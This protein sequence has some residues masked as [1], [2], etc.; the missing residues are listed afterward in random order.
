[1]AAPGKALT[2]G[3]QIQQL[4]NARKMVLE[5]PAYYD[6]IVKG[7]LPIIG[8]SSPI[9]LRRW[10]AEFLAESLATPVL[11]SR[12]KENLT[13]AILDTL[14]L[15][16]EGPNDDVLVF[17]SSVMAAASA[18]PI[19][20]RWIIHN[21]Y[22][23]ESW[24]AMTAIK[25]KILQIWD[26]AP[27]PV[28]IC[29]IKFVQRV[30]LAQTASN[31][32]EQK[33]NGLDV[34][35]AMIP[36]NHPLLDPRLLEAEAAGL[37]DR[38]LA[39]L[40]DN[41]SDAL[42]VDATLNTLAILIRTRPS[43]SNRILN[44]VL[45]F[46]PL[47]LANSPLTP[48]TKV[49]IKSMEK[50]TRILLLHLHKRDPNNPMAGRIQQHIERLSRSR[51]EIFDDA[52]RKRALVQPPGADYGEAKR[53]R[54]DNSAPQ[55]HARPWV[56][57][58]QSLAAVF[59]LTNTPGLDGF[60]AT[61]VPNE[62]AAKI[63]VKA[64]ATTSPQ[65][66][67]QAVDAV[68]FRLRTLYAAAPPVQPPALN[69][70]TQPLGVDEDDDDG[71]EPDYYVA[72]DTEQILNKLD[73]APPEEPVGQAADASSALAP[74]GPFKLPPPPLVDPTVAIKV[75]Q[76]ASSR[77]FGP[78][79]SLEEA[80]VRKHKAGINRLAASSYDRDSWL[81]LI[82]RMATRSVAGLEDVSS[83]IKAEDA[84]SA[85]DRPQMSLSNMIRELL[86]NYVLEDWRRR[87]EVAV[88]WLCEEWY[89]DQVTKRGQLDAP[90]H[91]EKWA[92]RL[93]DGFLNYITAQDKVLTRFLAEIPELSRAL[94]GRLKSVCGDPT[95]I[96]LVLTTLLY[97]VMMRPP[98]REIALDTVAAIWLEYEE[99]RPLASKYLIK[100]RPG[101][102]ES[103]QTGDAASSV[104]PVAT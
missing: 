28:R 93:V 2:V 99:A 86:Y 56:P 98:V 88:A 34:S 48:K 14:Q 77:V 95:K 16:V 6:K 74:L 58:P 104:M 23:K 96:Q 30:I 87:I 50:T 36:P 29:C 47:K 18:Y 44:T 3:E 39:V 80:A 102:I 82:T 4:N 21:S 38:M 24:E 61:Q 94:L 7:I 85:L 22:H 9:E 43:T 100:W 62:L 65:L 90:L 32:M 25:A 91:Y 84:R 92:L 8:P 52:N 66:L 17:K 78:L 53:Q 70:D 33:I 49:L 54:T 67:S 68:R 10:G 89:N 26:T 73:S 13:V 20:L 19:A 79:P 60:D 35:L 55:F 103:Q 57:G 101:F 31:G 81:T 15:L 71:Y 64:L 51:N 11:S 5:N 59:T 1:M 76:L 37:L 69:P 40:Q 97:L 75:G 63:T 45:G 72:E 12:D 27:T 46:N 83:G 42:L 41:S